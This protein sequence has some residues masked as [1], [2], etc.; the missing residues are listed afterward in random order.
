M[1]HLTFLMLPKVHL[2]AVQ[3]VKIRVE[4]FLEVQH[5]NKVLRFLEVRSRP[6]CSASRLHLTRARPVFLEAKVMQPQH[7][8]KVVSLEVQLEAPH[9]YL[10]V[11]KKQHS[12]LLLN[13]KI[14]YLVEVP[15]HQVPQLL[16]NHQHLGI[17]L[18]SLKILCLEAEVR[19]L[20]LDLL[21]N[22]IKAQFL[23]EINSKT[24]ARL[25][26]KVQFLDSRQP[27]RPLMYLGDKANL[28]IQLRPFL[29]EVNKIQL[30]DSSSK[31]EVNPYLV[32][33]TKIPQV[34]ANLQPSVNPP[35][36]PQLVAPY[37]VILAN[38]R[39]VLLHQAF[40]ANLRQ[41]QLHLPCSVNLLNQRQVHLRYLDNLPIVF[42]DNQ[43]NQ[44]RPLG[45]LNQPLKP[46]LEANLLQPLQHRP[47]CLVNL[48]Q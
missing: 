23:V 32:V 29:E 37:L 31:Q 14:Q 4:V 42:L 6:L 21:N 1:F 13:L 45:R 9:P 48:R 16:V 12:V 15:L 5:S 25:L 27:Q 17:K 35:V 36:Q 38:Q 33:Q 44:P 18:N 2:E 7:S 30:L 19:L 34:L 20:L 47:H 26:A 10:E 41:I 39:Q 40:L 28:K 8:H 22:R 43:A 11:N 24:K 46:H 3:E